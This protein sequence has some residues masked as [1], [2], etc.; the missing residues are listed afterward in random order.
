MDK[1]IL[2]IETATDACSVALTKNG[3]TI[4]EKYIDEPKAHASVIGG[5]VTDILKEN[6]ITMYDCS[7]VAVS[8]GPGSYTGLRVGVSC[9]KGLCYGAGKPLISVC[10]LATITQLALDN[11]LYS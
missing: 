7:A 5:Y 8:K 4:A 1:Y 10:T 9:A 11:N 3:T 2:L 6:C